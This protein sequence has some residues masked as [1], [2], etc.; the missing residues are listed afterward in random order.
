MAN[1]IAISPRTMWASLSPLNES[2]GPPA[3]FGFTVVESQTWLAQ[4]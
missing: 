1:R 3:P 4:P 2:T